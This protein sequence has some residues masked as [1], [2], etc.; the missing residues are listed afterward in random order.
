M[1]VFIGMRQRET[2]FHVMCLKLGLLSVGG[3]EFI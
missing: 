1:C 2:D 3:R